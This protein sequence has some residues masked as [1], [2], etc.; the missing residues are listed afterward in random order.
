MLAFKSMRHASASHEQLDP[1]RL[2]QRLEKRDLSAKLE[3][4]GQCFQ[5]GQGFMTFAQPFVEAAGDGQPHPREA[6]GATRSR[7]AA[8]A[9]T[10]RRT[11]FVRSYRFSE[12]M[13]ASRPLRS[14]SSARY[15]P[16]S[17]PG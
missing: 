1:L 8:S 14:I 17:T 6:F 12:R 3:P 10:T 2:G 5:I 7:I 16:A 4:L 15:S 13:T 11:F 9:C